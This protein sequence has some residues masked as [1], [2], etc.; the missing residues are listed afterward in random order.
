[1]RKMKKTLYT[2]LCLMVGVFP[3]SGCVEEYEAD[4]SSEDSNLLVVEGTICSSKLNKFYLS[5]AQA[6]NS[7]TP[8][9]ILGA[10]VTV[11]GTDGSE[12][13]AQTNG[14]YYACWID[15]LSP[16]VEYYLHIETDGEVYESEPQKPL[17]TEKIADVRGEQL[18][19]EST[20]DVFITP[21]DPFERDLANYYSWTY[22]ETWEVRPECRTVMY[23]DTE[24]KTPVY[25]D[26]YHFPMRGWLDA[27]SST[28]MVGASTNYDRQYI[29]GLK[30]YEISRNDSRIFYR[31]SGLVHQRAIS[32][33]EYEYELARRQAGSE[34]GGLFTP[35][36]SALPTNI[37]CLTSGKHVIGFVGCS[38]NT[39]K[40]RFFLNGDEY[41]IR[42]PSGSDTRIW[43][44]N[45]TAEDCCKMV[46]R[47]LY[48]CEWQV[49]EMSDDGKLH[50]I[51]A[52]IHQL[53]VR[54]RYE[55]AYVEEPD[56]WSL[57]ENVSY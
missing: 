33:A 35:Q 8:H 32:K 36:P 29:Q 31:Y 53:D 26:I 54:Y 7:Y 55:G 45:P 44:D 20:I 16:D 3:L 28:I 42:R 9:M 4:I 25:E 2:V 1:M 37:R 41:S 51:W 19:P 12:Y 14:D 23:F 15:R 52:Y 39:S 27:T 49:P 17:R 21:D 22:D 38:L 48:L 10:V 40:Y 24:Y 50:A 56:F 6:L 47:G 5:R 18:T 30:L 43:L 46:E 34:M 11:L 13:R 57:N